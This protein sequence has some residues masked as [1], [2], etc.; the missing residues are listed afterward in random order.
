[1]SEK[2]TKKRDRSRNKKVIIAGPS[3]TVNGKIY[4]VSAMQTTYGSSMALPD[5]EKVQ[6]ICAEAYM[7]LLGL[8][9]APPLIT[10]THDSPKQTPVDPAI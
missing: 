1:M 6:A 2:K 7:K 8:F 5:K 10:V 9:T 3:V 4:G